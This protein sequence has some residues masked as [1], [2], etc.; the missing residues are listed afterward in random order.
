MFRLG[1]QFKRWLRKLLLE[2]SI[3]RPINWS[4][5]VNELAALAN[6]WL[7]QNGSPSSTPPSPPS[8]PERPEPAHL[9]KRRERRE[10]LR[11][12]RDKL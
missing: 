10:R 6:R 12:L 5:K 1:L 4:M 8:S 11:Q 2:L 9:R 7:D 3:S